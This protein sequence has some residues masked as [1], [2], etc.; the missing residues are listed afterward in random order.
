MENKN[1]TLYKSDLVDIYA[2]RKCITKTEATERME[3]V[4]DIIV[5][6]LV[7]GNIVKL[8]NFFNFFPTTRKAKPGTNPVTKEDM[9]IPETKTLVVK[10]TKPVK[11]KVQGKK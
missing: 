4:F 5:T 9:V 11:D 10:M 3:D 6:E 8:A 2:E 7:K 1:N